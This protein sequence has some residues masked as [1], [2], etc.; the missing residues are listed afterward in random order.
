VRSTPTDLALIRRL[1]S[2]SDSDNQPEFQGGRSTICWIVDGVRRLDVVM[3]RRTN[4]RN[5][6]FRTPTPLCATVV[7][8]GRT[9]ELTVTNLLQL[10]LQ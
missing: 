5:L 7:R 3:D 8:A 10:R 6:S 1:L 2:N 4:G 9:P